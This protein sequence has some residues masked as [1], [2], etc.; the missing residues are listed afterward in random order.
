V[1]FL[2]QPRAS[3]RILAV[4]ASLALAL[5]LAVGCQ[6]KDDHPPYL[7]DCETNCSPL[8]G[9]SIGTGTSAGG[10]SSNPISDA[11]PGTLTG[12][13]LLLSDQTFAQG[14]LFSGGAIV[15][16][17]GASGSP[18]TGTW[19]GIDNY[20]IDSVAR[21]ATNWVSVKPNLAQGDALLTYQAVR[22][23]TTDTVN[24]AVVSATTLD[25]I[26]NALSAPARSPNFGQVVLFFRSSGTGTPLAGLHV[27]MTAAALAAYR[28]GTT[29]VEDDGTA[30]TDTNG[31]VLFG[32]VELANATGTQPVTVTKAATAST[33]AVNAGTFAAR[34]VEGAV[35]IATVDV[36]L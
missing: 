31:L 15:S 9:I 22:T 19:N 10:G 17:D 8:P 30:V 21:E 4:P 16:A 12:Q 34:V 2:D 33:G 18:V 32:N 5:T 35:S 24:L 11:G 29:W 13:V 1:S 25:A 26:F 6:K 14:M 7:A 20:E 36:A 27:A 23:S 28:S 3:W